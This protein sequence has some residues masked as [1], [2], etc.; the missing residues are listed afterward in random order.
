V[1]DYGAYEW[2][3]VDAFATFCRDECVQSIDTFDGQPLI[4][5]PWQY[6]L[7]DDAMRCNADTVPYWNSVAIVLPR[8]NGK[9]TMLAAYALYALMCRE[10]MPEILLCA[11]SDKQAGRLFDAVV[12]FVVRNPRLQ[13]QLIVR[14]WIGEIS[15]ADRGG[16]ILRM[17]SSP[18]RLH[19]YNPSLVIA[20]EVAQ[21]L[22]PSL[23]RAWAALTTAGGA[24]QLTQT[25]TISVAGAAHEREEGILGRLI[26]AN[27]RSGAVEQKTEALRISRNHE[28]RTLVFNYSAPTVERDDI[29]AIMSAN[30]ADWID[31][32]YIERQSRNPELTDADFLQFHGCVWS[33]AEDV[34]LAPRHWD[35]IE[36][37][38]DPI[39]KGERVA[40]GFD[41]SRF[42]DSTVLVACRLEDG[43]VAVL[44]AW[45]RPE[46]KAGRGWEV[47]VP[48]VNA[49]IE[50]AM[51]RFRVV[52]FYADPPY[53]QTE[54]AA[55]AH[56]FG[57]RIVIPWA[58]NRMTQ[59]SAAVER[60]RTDAIA[61]VLSHDGGSLLRRH[62][63]SAHMR[64][65][66]VGYWIEK[67]S[68]HSP[69]KIDAAVAA[70]LAYEARNDAIAAGLGRDRS[71]VPVS[72]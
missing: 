15:R 61:G 16:K 44:D 50:E 8:K 47:S 38:G 1:S 71:R 46:G 2:T 12:S 64:K 70:V 60:F 33:A 72:L 11:S 28:A 34:W 36:R 35:D 7:F 10:G 42:M 22:T 20:D 25:F 21:W 30:P 31:R 29:D 13:R 68:A 57:D 17:S 53:W 40:L 49:A 26:D 56:E 54:I 14:E 63:L 59:M 23:R 18:E 48:E 52:R 69:D 55:W 24:R 43:L 67:A 6:A 66:R 37:E 65:V 27:E 45:E 39:L 4:L 9:T 3:E 58:T 41:G 51:H 62:V 32:R 5:A 19:G